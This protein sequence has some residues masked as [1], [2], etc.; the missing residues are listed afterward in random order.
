VTLQ[1]ESNPSYLIELEVDGAG[2]AASGRRATVAVADTSLLLQLGAGRTRL[3]VRAHY[4]FKL[5]SP[6]LSYRLRIR[7]YDIEQHCPR[8][9]AATAT[10]AF[11]ESHDGANNTS[12]D[13]Y[14]VVNIG[15][16]SVVEAGSTDQPELIVFSPGVEIGK[17]Y[18]ISGVAGEVTA[19][20][21]Y[22]DGDNYKINA[23]D[24][25]HLI[26]RLDW[27]GAAADLDLFL[28]D[29]SDVASAFSKL[30]GKSG[31]EILS[32]SVLHPNYFRLWVGGSAASGN[33][34]P[35]AYTITICGQKFEP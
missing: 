19:L 8:G 13:S 34:Y 16:Q 26:V 14:R 27:D 28:F 6:E 21:D 20:D 12:N 7:P 35:Q 4:P 9:S 25:D 5:S 24:A 18:V 10:R 30:K 23:A 11:T 29:F 2:E 22:A 17:N 3:A 31:P 32:S 15:E 33:V 1:Y